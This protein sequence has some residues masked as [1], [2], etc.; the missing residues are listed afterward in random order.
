MRF[1]IVFLVV[2]LLNS[3]PAFAQSANILWYNRPAQYF[4]ETLV[5]GNSKVRASIFGSVQSD[6]IYLND[7]T[8]LSFIEPDGA[9][10]LNY[11]G[12]GGTYANLFDAQPPFQING[13]FGGAAG[14]IEMLLQSDE[15][16]IYLLPALPKSWTNGSV[17]GLKARGGFEVSM[18]W[19]NGKLTMCKIKSLLG[20]PCVVSYDGKIKTHK[21]NAG[22]SIRIDGEL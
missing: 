5:L 15:K 12:G 13:N 3:N 19:E 7:A 20:N 8:L 4:E 17:T 2:I 18:S 22:S 1:F 21:I 14:V 16:E 10:K 9:R 11:S 6:K